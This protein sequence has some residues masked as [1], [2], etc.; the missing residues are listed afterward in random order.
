MRLRMRWFRLMIFVLLTGCAGQQVAPVESGFAPVRLSEFEEPFNAI[1]AGLLL[2]G[3]DDGNWPGDMQG[4]ATAFAP[5]LFYTLAGH[6]A[7]YW[8]YAE[9]TVG[10]EVRLIRRLRPDMQTVIGFPAILYGYSFSGSHRLLLESGLDAGY[11]LYRIAPASLSRLVRDETTL[12]GTLAY[13]QLEAYQLLQD[14]KLL[15]RGL[16]LIEAAPFDPE[17]GLYQYEALPDWPQSTMLMALASA[18]RITAEPAYLER[19]RLVMQQLIDRYWDQECGGFFGHPDAQT[20]GLSGNNNL[21]WNL[22]DLYELTGDESYLERARATLSW[23]T[24][25]DLYH[26]QM[27]FHHW[28]TAQGRADYACSGCNFQTLWNIYRFNSML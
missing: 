28:T 5:L 7:E 10:H 18:Y 2:A 27:L 26:E 12:M 8:A 11:L 1:L 19:M 6:G 20:K 16:E 14:E 15:R 4:D 23:I 3:D 9:R 22:L 25:L 17:R 21:T 24:G 13:L